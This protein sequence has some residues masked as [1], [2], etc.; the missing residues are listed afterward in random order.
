[1]EEEDDGIMVV[2]AIL[3]SGWQ[4]GDF[5]FSFVTLECMGMEPW[6]A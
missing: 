1:M 5:L 4:L 6:V 3:L 2:A